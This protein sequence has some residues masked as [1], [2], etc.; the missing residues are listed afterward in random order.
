MRR[1]HGNYQR[2]AS[3]D[4]EALCPNAWVRLRERKQ[5][6][7]YCYPTFSG[8]GQHEVK[9]GLQSWVVD[10]RLFRCACGLW[11]LSGL[12]CQHALACI[13]HNKEAVEPY[14]DPCY[15]VASYRAAYRHP[16]KPLNDFSQWD[17][18]FGPNLRPPTIQRPT[19]G[20][21]Q[22][23][24]RLEA[25]ELISRKDKRGRPYSTVG[26][27]GQPQKCT[28]CKKT[29]HNRRA[30]GNDQVRSVIIRHSLHK[31]STD[32]VLRN[33]GCKPRTGTDGR[34]VL[35]DKATRT[36][37]PGGHTCCPQRS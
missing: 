22:R 31:C 32:Y 27:S 12:P 34:W 19:S 3:L 25:G 13:A 4:P 30:H 16:I 33:C 23:K 21:K 18:S 26:K 37:L 10:L 14:C 17:V 1:V 5:P 15:K 20:P 35:V 24:R 29:G 7:T 36:T 6:A 11:Q 9:E 28:I 2:L 8:D